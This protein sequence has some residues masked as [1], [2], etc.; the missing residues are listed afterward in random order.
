MLYFATF[1]FA[2]GLSGAFVSACGLTDA[3]SLA[4]NLARHLS[5]LLCFGNFGEGGPGIRRGAVA[6]KGRAE[7]GG[8]LPL[9]EDMSL[10]RP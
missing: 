9:G 2:R 1:V 10:N 3:L 4:C 5:F 7:A 8:R 6:Q